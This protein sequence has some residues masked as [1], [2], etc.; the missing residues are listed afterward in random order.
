MAQNQGVG[1]FPADIAPHQHHLNEAQREPAAHALPHHQQQPVQA[2][3]LPN[4]PHTPQQIQFAAHPPANQPE[5]PIVNEQSPD[6]MD[7]V[8][9]N[10]DDILRRMVH[11]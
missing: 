2:Q 9:K 5:Q 3:D 4:Q 8:V 11:P 6:G 10:H 1:R 7:E